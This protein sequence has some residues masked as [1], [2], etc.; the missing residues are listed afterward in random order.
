MINRR[1]FQQ[2]PG[3]QLYNI[4]KSQRLE[5]PSPTF[6]TRARV[7]PR[8]GSAKINHSSIANLVW[9]NCS[10]Y[11][12]ADASIGFRP[13][14]RITRSQS[15]AKGQFRRSATPPKCDSKSVWT[16]PSPYEAYRGSYYSTS[17]IFCS[18]RASASLKCPMFVV[19]KPTLR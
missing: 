17:A 15:L 16:A 5:V 7:P 19:T 12:N 4:K 9:I 6:T 3:S 11:G 13:A 10:S 18:H 1:V 14:M 2:R 8:Y